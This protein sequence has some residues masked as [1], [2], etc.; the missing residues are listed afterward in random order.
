MTPVPT[1]P[2]ETRATVRTFAAASF[3][4]DFGSDIIYPVWPFFV[5][6]L[7]GNKEVLGLLDGL[8]E[9][10][11]SIAQAVSGYLSDRLRK[12]KVFI[13]IGYLFGGLSRAGYAL[14]TAWPLLVPFRILDRAGKMRGAPRDAMVADVSPRGVRGRNFG[15][16]R[17]MD[18]LG[19]VGGIVFC[20]VFLHLG[21][22]T[23]FLIAA[24][25]SLLAAL[26][27]ALAIRDHPADEKRIFKGISFRHLDRNFRI[28]LLL[29]AVFSLGAFSYSFLM[30]YAV[31]AGI[32]TVWT[33]LL[34]LLFTLAA[35]LLSYWFGTLSDSLGRKSVLLIAFLLWA[36]V[37]GLLFLERTVTT[38]IAAFALYGIH[39][40]AL[41]PVQKALV[42]DLAPAELR[43][44]SLGGYQMVVGLCALP[45][46]IMAGVLWETVS[47]GLPLLVSLSLSVVAI[48]LL[49]FVEQPRVAQ[50]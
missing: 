9:A 6:A 4:N 15:L 47:P 28:F 37:C 29:S 10:I 8:G 13:W 1:S 25:P 20:M 2:T 49:L 18:N 5:V 35:S 23:L 44:S 33:P 38:I 12:R 19:A 3:L 30:L 46:S 40:A 24:V 39:K 26:L 34:Y 32:P 36:L 17:S 16:L 22:A 31:D 7:G 14:S 42:S 43:A 41:E 11:V 45:S 27:I 48:V 21:Y 50:S